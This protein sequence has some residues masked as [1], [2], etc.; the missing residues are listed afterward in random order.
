MREACPKDVYW[1]IKMAD[2]LISDNVIKTQRPPG[3]GFV[4]YCV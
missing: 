4:S 1:H 3:G 2:F